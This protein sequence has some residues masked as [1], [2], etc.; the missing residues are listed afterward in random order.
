MEASFGIAAIGE[1]V[2][3]LLRLNCSRYMPDSNELAQ[4]DN[5]VRLISTLH[6]LV[7]SNPDLRYAIFERLTKSDGLAALQQFVNHD[8]PSLD[9]KLGHDS[10]N[11]C[12]ATYLDIRLQVYRNLAVMILRIGLQSPISNSEVG[13][14]LAVLVEKQM[15]LPSAQSRCPGRPS[16]IQ[17]Q[18]SGSLSL[19]EAGST[20]RTP[21]TS[22]DWRENV[23]RELARDVSRQHEFVVRMLG[24][25]CRDLELRCEEAE[26][27]FREEQRKS[28]DLQTRL[29][30]SG[31]KLTELEVH[32]QS[33]RLELENLNSE[34][35]SLVNR[36]ESAE[37]RLQQMGKQLDMVYQE[38]EQA[39]SDFELAAQAAQE[40]YREQDLDYISVLTGKDLAL[41]ERANKIAVTENRIEMLENE[42]CQQKSRT[43]KDAQIISRNE[44]CMAELNSDLAKASASAESRLLDIERLTA[45]EA[46]LTDSKASIVEEAEQA[47]KRHQM[48]YSEQTAQ[49]HSTQNKLDNLENEYKQYTC[50]RDAQVQALD[51]DRKSMCTKFEMDIEEARKNA[52]EASKVS[53]NQIAEL[54]AKIKRLRKERQER[55][56][57]V[58]EARTMKIELMAFI[59]QTNDQA[60]LATKQPIDAED[61]G[62]LFS[63]SDPP[64]CFGS[65]ESNR[66]GPTSKRTKRHRKSPPAEKAK[67]PKPTANVPS[68][69]RSRIVWPRTPLANIDN[70]PNSNDQGP[71]QRADWQEPQHS[72]NTKS[73]ILQENRKIQIWNSD[74]ESFEGG[75]IFTSTDPGQASATRRITLRSPPNSFDGTTTDF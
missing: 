11:I 74:D 40:K 1:G 72:E 42:L 37:G 15:P 50:K 41:E 19:F 71:T 2:I 46:H 35:N 14:L 32:A 9:F 21:T 25:I 55:A 26:R 6:G 10:R 45:S 58:T 23:A 4:F 51:E 64:D 13:A 70:A 31:I 22:H 36:A 59:G 18:Q 53:A 66:S 48:L 43:Q 30:F 65:S 39:K 69:R 56:R 47:A 63:S 5:A 73:E 29:D 17:L 57:E 60:A 54:K 20:P 7:F 34:K 44:T 27:P 28:H 49:L 67:T 12:S 61:G 8:S 38:F 75:E 68:T 52:A 33:Q 16:N 62:P 24:E 3:G